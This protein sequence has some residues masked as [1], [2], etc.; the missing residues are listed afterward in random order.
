[1]VGLLLFL[2]ARIDRAG[3][4]QVFQHAEV[5]EKLAALASK[6]STGETVEHDIDLDE[7]SA[8]RLSM[9]TSTMRLPHGSS[10]SAG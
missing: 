9:T 7:P 10:T 1:M 2:R 4:V 8:E 3:D 5:A 6:G